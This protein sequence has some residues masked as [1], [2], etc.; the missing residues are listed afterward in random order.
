MVCRK[1]EIS[2]IS[3]DVWVG[4]YGSAIPRT[5]GRTASPT[6]AIRLA[7]CFRPY[8]VYCLAHMSGVGVPEPAPFS[9][10]N[11]DVGDQALDWVANGDTEHISN[12]AAKC[13][14][15]LGVSMP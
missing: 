3:K 11:E 9:Q 5:N 10:R 12:S 13:S 14:H 2:Y 1:W 8:V 7:L 6:K 4:R 15:Y